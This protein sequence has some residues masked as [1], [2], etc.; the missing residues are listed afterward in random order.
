MPVPSFSTVGP[1][2]SRTHIGPSAVKVGPTVSTFDDVGAVVSVGLLDGAVEW[3]PSVST[4]NITSDQLY[5]PYAAVITNI[6]HTVSFSLDQVDIYNLALGIGYLVNSTTS[7]SS[8]FTI[9][10]PDSVASYRSLQIETAGVG[11]DLSGA[12]GAT[13]FIEFFRVLLYA[14]GSVSYGKTV[15]STLPVTAL[16][17]ANDNDAVG[18]VRNSAT[19]TP[20]AYE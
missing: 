9:G 16:C 10:G 1:K 4:E 12:S 15:K 19:L 13:Q 6:E 2:I 3:N 5:H 11:D 14:S 17:L 20:P 8:L 7:G 18:Q